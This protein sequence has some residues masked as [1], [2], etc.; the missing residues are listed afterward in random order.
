MAGVR[1]VVYAPPAEGFPHLAIIIGADGHVLMCEAVPS[2][3]AGEHF[4]FEIMNE[5]ARK[6][7][8]EKKSS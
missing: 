2:R 8:E 7:R 3:D 4:L 5:F 1:A 6:V